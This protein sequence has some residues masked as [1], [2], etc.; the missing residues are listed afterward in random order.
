VKFL[1]ALLPTGWGLTKWWR[2]SFPF[3]TMGRVPADGAR[4]GLFVRQ[5]PVVDEA[6]ETVGVEIAA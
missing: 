3:E 5:Y 2:N 6:R 4:S 1:P